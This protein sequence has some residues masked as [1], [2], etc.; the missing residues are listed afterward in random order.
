M[1]AAA[2]AAGARAR[3]SVDERLPHTRPASAMQ[4]AGSMDAW[5]MLEAVLWAVG[6]WA[7]ATAVALV[8]VV[9]VVGSL[10]ETYFSGEA[11]PDAARRGRRLRQL[12][13][14]ALGVMLIVLGAL[15][16]IPGVPGQGV[17]TML[18]GV[19]LLD[20]P[21]RHRVARGIA[22]WPGV[23]TTLN[24]VRG[25]LGRP[26][27]CPPQTPSQDADAR[28]GTRPGVRRSQRGEPAPPKPGAIP[29]K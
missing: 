4:R 14:N 19:I 26:P 11:A 16:S 9:L 12:A 23:L 18:A 28:R 13:R 21:G 2:P 6:V 15:L 20:F 22:R 8:V 17:L 10:P 1:P 7:A 24:A 5:S 3:W 29:P 27:L 25:R